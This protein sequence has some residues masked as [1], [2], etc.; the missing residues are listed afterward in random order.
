MNPIMKKKDHVVWFDCAALYISAPPGYYLI[1]SSTFW[2]LFHSSTFLLITL[3]LLS[4]VPHSLWNN[5]C[6]S[7][8]LQLGHTHTDAAVSA[9]AKWKD[10]RWTLASWPFIDGAKNVLLTI[11]GAKISHLVLC[12]EWIVVNSE[13]RSWRAWI[14][15]RWEG[16]SVEHVNGSRA[17]KNGRSC[18]LC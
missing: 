9:R 6:L 3:L 8:L 1:L 15:W 16:L 13:C 10:C 17:R 4:L 7:L 11:G 5:L 14:L 2:H 12:K 18:F